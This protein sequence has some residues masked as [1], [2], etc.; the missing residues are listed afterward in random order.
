MMQGKSPLTEIFSSE[1]VRWV[2]FRLLKSKKSSSFL[3]LI[4]LLSILGI[5]VGVTAMI[6]VLSVMDGFEDQLKSRL[7]STQLHVLVKHPEGI[8]SANESEFQELR[9]T[10]SSDSRVENA[11][12]VLATEAILRH[13]G[14]V[15]GVVLKGIANE[16]MAELHQNQI[17]E[18]IESSDE[19]KLPLV[20]VGQEL[21]YT[22]HL[23]PGDI[24]TFISPTE[25]EGP[26]SQIPRLKRFVLGGVYRSGLPEQ[27]LQ[28]LYTGI[29][30]VQSFIRKRNVVSQWEIAVQDFDQAPAVA[31]QIRSVI[32]NLRVRDWIQMNANLFASLKLERVSMFI[33]MIFIVIVASFNIVTTLTMMVLEKKKDIS[34]LRAMGARPESVGAIFLSEGVFIGLIGVGSGLILSLIICTIL[35]SSDLIALPDIYYDRTLPVSFKGLYYFGVSSAALSVVFLAC[36]YPS[37][38]ASKLDPIQG[39]RIG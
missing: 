26:M 31:N 29:K 8:V 39:I 20:Y 27:E 16:Q 15:K 2:G 22:M 33:A 1:W 7:M 38:R 14:R 6:V 30:K 11:F 35:G 10:L 4:T 34:I 17:V 9:E 21:A 13:A 36:L 3:S 19:I 18:K 28:V 37:R 25:T 32:P 5:T 23:I 12:G 24:L